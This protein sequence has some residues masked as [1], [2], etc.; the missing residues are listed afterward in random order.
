MKPPGGHGS[1]HEGTASLATSNLNGS[2]NWEKPAQAT[3]SIP[4]SCLTDFVIFDK[5]ATMQTVA[6][7]LLV[8]G[9]VPLWSAWRA[10]RAWALA[11]T[12]GW[13]CVAWTVWLS[14]FVCA[15]QGLDTPQLFYAALCLTAGSIVAILGAR[16]PGVTAWNAVVLALLAVL[17]IPLAESYLGDSRLRLQWFRVVPLGGILA[18][19]VL[20]YLPTRL[21]SAALLWGLTH[22]V[23]LWTLAG[24]DSARNILTPIL[25]WNRLALALVPWLAFGL[26]RKRSIPSFDADR[27]WLSFRDRFGFLWAQRL[28]E[29]MNRSAAHAGWP[30]TLTWRGFRHTGRNTAPD[31]QLR[32]G[33]RSVLHALMKRFAT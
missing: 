3:K 2:S 1:I 15:S 31:E 22:A 20:N 29:Q 28:R 9:I 6:T 16:R 33:V 23:E 12:I 4:S 7:I 14:A 5:T 18:V 17:L 13:S 27:L 8:L 25:P 30:M 11:H 21:G 32:D 10:N 26:M 19:G 24:S